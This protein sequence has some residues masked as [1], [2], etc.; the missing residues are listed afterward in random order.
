MNT[1]TDTQKPR[2][3]RATSDTHGLWIDEYGNEVIR[4]RP[5]WARF[6][7]NHI[8]EDGKACRR[9][10]AAGMTL[11][12]VHYKLMLITKKGHPTNENR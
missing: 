11:C 5:R 2:Y 7:C 12:R 6:R 4:P 1:Q 9:K 3:V 8:G 10:Q